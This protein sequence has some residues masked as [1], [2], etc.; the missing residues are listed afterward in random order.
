MKS[1]RVTIDVYEKDR[2]AVRRKRARNPSVIGFTGRI[3]LINGWAIKDKALK[4]HPKAT[5]VDSVFKEYS[6]LDSGDR[7]P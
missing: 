5:I 1:F 4:W 3:L 6:R 2:K 7:R